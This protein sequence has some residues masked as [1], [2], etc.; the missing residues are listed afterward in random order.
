MGVKN[1]KAAA[2]AAA[3]RLNIALDAVHKSVLMVSWTRNCCVI[4]T[5]AFQFTEV[6]NYLLHEKIK[7]EY[8]WAK[9][10]TALSDGTKNLSG[11]ILEAQRLAC[12]VPLVRQIANDVAELPK[13]TA[14][15][16][17]QIQ[18]G[19]VILI[20]VVSLLFSMTV[21]LHSFFFSF[22]TPLISH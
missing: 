17:S 5:E 9:V 20:D 3:I 18:K 16:G 10:K 8:L 2:I 1:D 11:Y 19:T 21:R 22:S 15:D 6:L 13:I 14:S 7:D 12:H 4:C